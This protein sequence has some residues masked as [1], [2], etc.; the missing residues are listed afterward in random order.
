MIDTIYLDTCALN[1]LTDD[2]SQPRVRDEA[3]AVARIL[4]AVALA[5]VEWVGSSAVRAELERNSDI[6]R[7]VDNLRVLSGANRIITPTEVTIARARLFSSTLA[8]LD[9][10]HLAL[11]EQAGADWL[12]TTDDRFIR[13]SARINLLRPHVI[14]PVEWVQRRQPWLLQTYP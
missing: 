11:C 7:R 13:Q 4:N 2:H 8:V 9:A 5:K 12:L 6:I 1:R 3:H 14:N 10:L